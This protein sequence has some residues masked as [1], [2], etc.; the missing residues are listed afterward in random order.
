[1]PCCGRLPP[2]RTKCRRAE[3][4]GGAPL[5]DAIAPSD[6]PDASPPANSCQA[7]I[8]KIFYFPEIRICRIVR[9]SRLDCG[10]AYRDRHDTRGG[11]A[12]DADVPIDERH[13]RGR[14]SRVVL[15]RPCRRQAGRDAD[16]SWPATVANKLVHWGEPEV[17]RKPLRRE[18][19]CDSAYLWLL[20]CALFAHF[21]HTG[22]RVRRAPGLP[23]ALRVLE[24]VIASNAR[25]RMRGEI[26]NACLDGRHCN[27]RKRRST[28]ES[29]M[30]L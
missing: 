5:L 23:C 16:A 4:C 20:P 27:E 29:R 12:V 21:L 9:T 26:A 15:A 3:Q 11:L 24:R 19:R 1:M 22:P 10:G 13:D 25:A 6:L 14:R 30:R 2:S 17:S 7:L 8:T 28:P 18:G